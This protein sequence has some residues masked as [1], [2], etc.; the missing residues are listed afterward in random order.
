MANLSTPSYWF[1][2]HEDIV[3][4]QK[5]ADQYT[6]PFEV[7]P[8]IDVDY[9]LEVDFPDGIPCKAAWVSNEL[10]ETENYYPINLRASWE[11]LDHALFEKA[12]KA[13]QIL[14]WDKNSRFC[15]AC[16]TKT[17][18]TTPITKICPFC[19]KELYP[20][21]STAI[22]ALVQKGD[23]LLL[24]RTYNFRGTFHSLVAGFLEAGETLE[25]CVAREVLEETGLTVDNITYFGN[26]PW[27]FPSGLMVGYI[28]NYVSGDIKLQDDELIS[29]AF[30]TKENLPE[31]PRKLSLARKM[32]DWW[33]EG[34][35]PK[36]L[37]LPI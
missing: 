19:S 17:N 9:S 35:I 29:G 3:L 26:Q 15:P 28:C 21:I 32:I 31:L 36:N 12:G 8:P 7:N 11:L 25:Q 33:L 2:F 20:V 5:E 27:P 37:S 34:P 30:Y 4:L 13:S 22:L 14:Y 18:Q 16:G 23:S 10:E 24:V 6:I 1:I